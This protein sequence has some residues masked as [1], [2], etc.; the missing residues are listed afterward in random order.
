MKKTSVLVLFISIWISS[1]A[2]EQPR[3]TQYTIIPTLY[4]P[5]TIG[6]HDGIR[7]ASIYRKQWLGLN[8]SPETQILTV[9][10]TVMRKKIGLGIIIMNDVLG[11]QRQQALTSTFSYRKRMGDFSFLSIGGALGIFPTSFDPAN[12][13]V[14]DQ[15]DAL[16]QT[17]GR[18][19]KTGIDSRLGINFHNERVSYGVGITDIF[20]R[21]LDYNKAVINEIKGQSSQHYF[22]TVQYDYD[23]DENIKYKQALLVKTE[24]FTRPQVDFTPMVEFNK[25]ILVGLSYRFDESVCA[26]LQWQ[27]KDIRAGI[28]F[29]R[30]INKVSM[31]ND[32]TVEFSLSY[33]LRKN[34]EIL[35]NPRLF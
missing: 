1:Y 26:I 12:V 21:K 3:F 15:N 28:A 9:D 8:G 31:V 35:Y 24:I 10:G 14:K 22:F 7:A 20:N 2:Q 17:T 6:V 11:A 33:I 4:N 27:I 13:R 29:D 34:R 16:I 32:G 25:E 23:I 5:A 19:T 18:E 30:S